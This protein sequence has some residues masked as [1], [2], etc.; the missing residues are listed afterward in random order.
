[1][2]KWTYMILA[3]AVALSVQV[4]IL[5]HAETTSF[6]VSAS[7]PEATGATIVASRVN[8]TTGVFSP[9]AGT[10]LSFDPLTYDPVNGIYLPNHFFAIDIGAVGGAGAP[11][12]VVNYT[13]GANP[14]GAGGFGLGFHAAATFVRVESDDEI[15]LTAHGPKKLLIQLSNEHITTAETV[16]GFLRIYTGLVTGDETTPEGGIPFTNA[17]QPG[18]Y[19]GTLVV[20]ATVP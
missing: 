7:V 1:M 14:N 4:Q 19:N 10:N 16:G 13:E 9:V 11:D 3:A 17:D 6:L 18:T 2:R 15:P 8:S 12:V 5:A 20:T